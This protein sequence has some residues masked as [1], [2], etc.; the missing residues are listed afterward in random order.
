MTGRR[1]ITLSKYESSAHCS[2]P[3]AGSAASACSTKCG[4]RIPVTQQC[5]I[6]TFA[7]ARASLSRE[8]SRCF[9][10]AVEKTEGNTLVSAYRLRLQPCCPESSNQRNPRS[11][12]FRTKPSQR[13]TSI[14]S[15]TVSVRLLRA[16]C[17]TYLPLLRREREC[18]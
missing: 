15:L 12:A 1:L 16:W 17:T 3:A 5:Q 13:N 6:G 14:N 10:S 8:T 7:T 4:H 2:I 9:T 18:P 11:L